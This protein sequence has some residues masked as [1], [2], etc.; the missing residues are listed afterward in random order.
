MQPLVAQFERCQEDYQR[1][2]L[3]L[4]AENET[5]VREKRAIAQMQRE[6]AAAA[7]QWQQLIRYATMRQIS[8]A[9]SSASEL[10]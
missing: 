1:K 8:A 3:Q 9:S 5:A 6:T 7:Q 10:G 4:Q 2:C